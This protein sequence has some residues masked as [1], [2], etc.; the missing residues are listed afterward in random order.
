M[1][2]DELGIR[3]FDVVDGDGHYFKKTWIVVPWTHRLM[4]LPLLQ[5]S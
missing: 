5:L 4:V 3:R 2:P 1:R